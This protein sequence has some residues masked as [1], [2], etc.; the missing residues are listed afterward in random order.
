MLEKRKPETEFDPPLTTKTNPLNQ[1]PYSYRYYL[2]LTNR[3]KLPIWDQRDEIMEAL[4]RDRVIFI[5]GETGSGKSTQL[6]HML[7][8]SAKASQ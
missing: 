7:L 5:R 1:Q 6:L 8:N 4:D 2:L 3:M